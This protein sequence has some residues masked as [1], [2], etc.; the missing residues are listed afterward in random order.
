MRSLPPFNEFNMMESNLEKIKPSQYSFQNKFSNSEHWPQQVQSKNYKNKFLSSSNKLQTTTQAPTSNPTRSWDLPEQ[1]TFSSQPFFNNPTNTVKSPSITTKFSSQSKQ[2]SITEKPIIR[3]SEPLSYPNPLDKYHNDQDV[4]IFHP[5]HLNQMEFSFNKIGFIDKYSQNL[6]PAKSFHSEGLN[7]VDNNSQIAIQGNQN[8]PLKS[9]SKRG[10]FSRSD[11]KE[12]KAATAQTN[13][14]SQ[15]LI[16]N[17]KSYETTT[18]TPIPISRSLQTIKPVP[19]SYNFHNPQH[20]KIMKQ[21]PKSNPRKTSVPVSKSGWTF[22]DEDVTT[23]DNYNDYDYND[24][25]YDYDYNYNY[26]Y[27]SRRSSES[28]D[29]HF[30]QLHFSILSSP[31]DIPKIGVDTNF[32]PIEVV[33]NEMFSKSSKQGRNL[34]FDFAASNVAPSWIKSSKKPE[35]KETNS[36]SYAEHFLPTPPPS[37]KTSY[38]KQS[39]RQQF[40]KRMLNI[41]P[42]SSIERSFKNYEK[43]MSLSSNKN[44]EF[45]KTRRSNK[46]MSPSPHS[47]FSSENILHAIVQNEIF[48]QSEK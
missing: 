40:A 13:Y 8:Y 10:Q 48:L 36:K 23:E 1:L 43:P 12:I 30:N 19:A 26:A 45:Q 32:R 33:Y 3:F 35:V 38:S 15:S 22:L 37:S 11:R 28:S 29:P 2:K 39:K 44:F 21:I 47:S 9:I 27:A 6:P 20:Q 42:S 16:N 24:N 46:S 41:N 5:E 25:N 31:V 17:I 34:D 14:L 18:K 7:L 4:E